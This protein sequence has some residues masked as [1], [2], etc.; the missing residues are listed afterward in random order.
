[1]KQPLFLK[2]FLCLTVF[3]IIGIT[4]TFA[5]GSFSVSGVVKD[6]AGEPLPGANIQVR[7][8]SQG[9]ISS[10]EGKFTVSNVNENSVLVV[11][12]LGY[13]ETNITIG[14]QRVLNITL[15]ED[16]QLLD[17]VVVVGYGTMKRSDLAGS[18]SSIDNTEL[19]KSGK[20]NTI[21]A[22]QG[23]IPGL[24]I[25]RNNNRPGG[26][27][28]MNIRGLS[29]TGSTTPLV[30][31][32]GVAGADINTLNAEDIEKIDI[33]KDTSSASIYGSR[34][35]NGVIQITTK[36]GASGKPTINY[37]GY[38]GFKTE[39]NKPDFMNG[40]EF[41][42]LSREY[43]RALNDNVYKD[44]KK[45]FTDPSEYKAV[46]DRNYYDWYDAISRTP[47]QTNH[48]ISATGGTDNV[49]YTIGAAYY[50]EQ[51]M[52][53]PQEYNR[54]N[55]RT[56]LDIKANKYVSF[57][58]HIYATYYHNDVG[59]H[60]IMNDAFRAKPLQHP[61]SLVDGSEL[62]KFPSNGIFNPL[63]T[64]KN[65]TT[66]NRGFEAFGNVYLNITP[67][68]GLSL[69][70]VFSPYLRSRGNGDYRD[71]WTKALQGTQK[72]VANK[73]ENFNLDYTWDNIANYN[74]SLLKDHKFDVTGIFSMQKFT[75]DNMRIDAK[76]LPY[77]SLWYRLQSGTVTRYESGFTQ[78]SLMSYTARVNYNFKDRYL[79][80]VSG[81]YDGSS[82]LAEGHKWAFFPAA[83]VAWR[84][85]QEAFLNQV[86]W[87]SNLKLR[88]SVGKTGNDNISP[89]KSLG[90]LAS[91]QYMFG[92]SVAPGFL[93]GSLA[94]D[95]LTWEKTTEYNVAV[96]F[97]FFNGRINGS[98]EYYDRLSEGMIMSKTI[99]IHT[100]YSSVD[101]N[102]ADIR[103]N[104]LEILLNTINVK[105]RDFQWSTS[106]NLAYNK[107]RIH[108][109]KFK[110]D[111]GQYSPQ[112]KGRQGD[113]SGKYIIGEPVRINWT[114][115][116]DGVW[117]LGEEAEAKKYDAKP[118]QW[119][120]RDF[121]GDG[122]I[123]ANIDQD[124]VGK[125]TPDWTGGMTN[126]FEYK[127]F[128]LS[129]QMYFR[130]GLT[131]RNQFFV[132]YLGEGNQANCN[133]LRHDYWTPENPTN[134]YA[135]PGNQGKFRNN[136]SRIYLKA[137]YLK[138]GYINLGYTFTS[139]MLEKTPL[140][141]LRLY[142]T[143]QNP[144]IFTNVVGLDPENPEST[145]AND[146]MMTASFLFGVN[147]SF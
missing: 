59:N 144:F 25:V 93:P 32:D 117:Q 21:S 41:A 138:V 94:N 82:K 5:Q 135:Q 29:T 63:V 4:Q 130:T 87:L 129:F 142:T 104:G 105:T 80:T 128:D 44:D 66:Q 71:T 133:N 122:V 48:N 47:I 73:T 81:R 39:I 12:F 147:L 140:S 78:S 17:E 1:M 20:T 43:H 57:G 79:L 97:G 46:Q 75:N 40:D 107:N 91:T 42:Q 114:Y 50:K 67:I 134:K 106:I 139:K 143:V 45:V 89:Y 9:T 101:D 70:T 30:V 113:F 34:G 123:S 98:I 124:I 121:D 127:N 85:N 60:D 53:D 141:K 109:L 18:I 90:T 38:V 13:T 31:I 86:D 110:E 49:K 56:S 24:S 61:N 62:W 74:F 2:L 27:Y 146:S 103:N 54:Y 72:P 35:T 92:E 51:G 23:Q 99:P 3:L 28:S 131:A 11:S 22:L 112:L 102:V 69:K 126:T 14:K 19:I 84:I 36:R 55:F 52:L 8:T 137:D 65:V 116:C 15:Q 120:I 76:D 115:I 96:D 111:L 37:S 83:A 33:L 88:F 100:G 10:A 7:G 136:S 125:R 26:G 95:K 6:P 16:R 132:Y 64:Q 58:G 145:V 108:D 118:G 77:N 68:D 119:K